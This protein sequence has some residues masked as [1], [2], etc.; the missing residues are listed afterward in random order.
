MTWYFV[1]Q[2]AHHCLNYLHQIDVNWQLTCSKRDLAALSNFLS[3]MAL[4]NLFVI[5]SWKDHFW[6]LLMFTLIN[7]H[8]FNALLTNNKVCNRP[9]L[10][11]YFLPFVFSTQWTMSKCMQNIADD[12]NITWV[13][14]CRK[15]PLWP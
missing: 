12:L 2:V 14:L 8:F 3:I 1:L 9:F 7:E 5:P 10:A 4:T 6:P 11:S 15:R 13:V